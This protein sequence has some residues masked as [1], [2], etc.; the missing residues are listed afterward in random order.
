MIKN[1]V[2]RIDSFLWAENKITKK[3]N[4]R[5]ISSNKGLKKK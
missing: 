5:L 3:L 1:Y 2:A 4:N